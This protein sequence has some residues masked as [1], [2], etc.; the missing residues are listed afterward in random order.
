[1]TAISVYWG[2]RFKEERYRANN[3]FERHFEQHL[4]WFPL[5]RRAFNRAMDVKNKQIDEL[6]KEYKEKKAL[7]RQQN[8]KYKSHTV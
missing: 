2:Q 6:K 3:F 1:M 4:E 8:E 7:V 5:T